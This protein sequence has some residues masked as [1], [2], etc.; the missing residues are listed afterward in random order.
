MFRTSCAPDRR[1]GAP[2]RKARRRT[3]VALL[4]ICLVGTTFTT[5][6]AATAPAAGAAV[7]VGLDG[8]GVIGYLPLAPGERLG[9]SFIHSVD[10]LPVEDWYVLGEGGLVQ[11]STRL[12]QFGAGMGHIAGQGKGHSDGDWWVVAGMN[13]PIGTLVLRVGSASVDHRLLYRDRQLRL[14]VCWPRERLTLRPVQTPD[15]AATA[16]VLPTECDR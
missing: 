8:V 14:S 9:V 16:P 3:T 4:V 2:R 7:V 11:E 12:I 13:R 10:K 6:T 15:P 1:R 5:T